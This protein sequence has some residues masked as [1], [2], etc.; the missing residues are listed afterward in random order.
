MERN[1]GRIWVA[2]L[3]LAL[4]VVVLF[5]GDSLTPIEMRAG[6]A[7]FRSVLVQLGILHIVALFVERSRSA[8]AGT[9][10]TF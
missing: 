1:I 2:L 8:G 4:A 5:Q 7:P 3:I 9:W 6:E 10:M